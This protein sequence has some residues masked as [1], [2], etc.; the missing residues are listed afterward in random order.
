MGQDTGQ[1]R[2]SEQDTD[3]AI[4]G[5]SAHLPGADG[6]GAYW[7]NLA[8][9]IRS[10]RKLDDAALLEAGERPDRLRDPN[11]VRAAAPLDGFDMFDGEFFGFSPRDSAILDPQHRRF[12]ETAWEALENAGHVPERFAGEI[13]V[14]AGCGMGSYLYFNLCSHPDLVRDVGMFL[15]RHTGNDK[16]FLAT[17]VSNIFDLRGPSIGVQTACS[18]SL[19]AVHYAARALLSGDCDMAL[20]GGVTIEL[21]QGRGYVYKPGEVLSPDGECHAFDARAEGTVF[22]SGAGVVVLRRLSDALADGDHI[23]A[24]LKGSA[25]NNDG[26]QKAGYLAPSVGRQADAVA[27]A[28]DAA[29]VPA[30]SI[31]YVECHGTGTY[32]GDPIEISALTDAFRR[33]TD[34]RGFCRIGSVKTNIGHL[35]TA[36]GAASLIKA[37]LALHHR[38][39]PPSLG[40]ETPNPAIDFDSSPFVVNDT[41]A[42]WPADWPSKGA[43]R[44]AGV[45]SL[46]VGGTNAHAVLEEAPARGAS[47]PSDWPFHILNVSGRSRAALDA[48]AARLAAHLRAHPEQPLADVAF[49]LKEG[50]RAFARR[51]VLV[52]ETHEEAAA[53]LEANDPYRVFTHEALGEDPGVVFMFP[54]GGAQY[55]GMARDLYETEP[56]FRDWMDR[57]LGLLQPELDF[58]LRAVWL[59]EPAARDAAEARLKTP[60]VQL[61]L[62]MITEYAL[63]QLWM[64]WGVRPAALVGHSMGENTAACLAGVIPFADCI[65]LV[66]LRGRLFDTVPKGGMLSVAMPADALRPLL[67]ADLDIACLNAPEMTVLSGPAAAL[68]A[69]EARLDAE[70]AESRRIGIDIAAHSRMLDPILAEF[71]D[72]LRGLALSAPRIPFVS[73]RTGTWITDEQATDPGYWAGHL[74][75]AVRF[76]DCI[77]TLA[78]D[79]ARVYLEVG[80]GAALCSLAKQNGVPANQ[81]IQSLRHPDLD[82][83]DDAYFLTVVGRLGAV[84][85]EVDWSPIWADQHRHRVPLPTYAFQRNRYFIAPAERV[86]EAAPDMPARRDDPADWGYLPVWRPAYADCP[87][88]IEAALAAAPQCWLI[89]TDTAGLGARLAARL[90][91]AGHDVAEVA[92]GDTFARTGPDSYTLAPESGRGGYDALLADLGAAGRM[93]TR[94]AHLWLVTDTEDHRPGSSFFHRNVEQGLYGL[95]H[96]A[97]ALDGA[98]SGPVHVTLATTGAAQVRT[99]P[100]AH[101]EKAMAAAAASVIPRELPGVTLASVDLE[102]AERPGAGRR[103]HRARQEEDRLDRAAAAL[104]EEM[105]AAPSNTVAAWRGERRFE[106]RFDARPLPQPAEGSGFARGGTYLITGGFGGIGLALARHLAAEYGARVA[107]VS[108]D[109]AGPRRSRALDAL[110]AAGAEVMAVAA[111]VC[112]LDDMRRAVDE[113]RA[114]FGAITGVIHA[115]GTIDDAPLLARTA[116][117]AEAVLAPKVHGTRVLDRLFPDGTLDLMVLCSSSST[118]TRPAGQYDYV[119]ANEYLN[120]FAKARRGGATRVVAVDWGIWAE[121]GMA[122]RALSGKGAEVPLDMPL[123]DSREDAASGVRLSARLSP[124][125]WILDEHRTEDGAAVLPGTG[126]LELAAEAMR[127]MGEGGPFE[128][129]DLYFL[130]PLGVAEGAQADLRLSLSPSEGG[131]ALDLRSIHDGRGTLLH[132]E[133]RLAPHAGPAPAQLDLDAIAARCA[134]PEAAVQGALRSPQEAHLRFGARWGVLRS[135]ALGQGEGL[136]RLALPDA[137]HA[138]TRTYVLHPAL[139]DIATGWAIDLAQGYSPD[140]LWVPLRYGRVIVHRPLPPEIA[141]WVRIA[142]QADGEVSFDITLA[143]PDGAVCVEIT[144]FAMSRMEGGLDLSLPARLDPDPDAPAAASPAQERLR[145]QLA[146]GIRPAEGAAALERAIATGAPQIVVSP[147]DLAALIRQA[148]IPPDMPEAG[149]ARPELDSAYAAP[150]TTTERKLAS[151]WQQLLGV[152][153]IGTDDSFFDLGGHSLIAVRLFAAIKREFGVEFPISTLFEAPTIAA[154]AALIDA[155]TGGEAGA[156]ADASEAAA[157]AQTFTHLVPLGGQGAR[158]GRAPFFLVAG[159]FGNVMNLRHL[160]QLIGPRRAVYG[161]QARGLLGGMDPHDTLEAAAADCIAEL[162]QVQPEGPYLL[163]GFSGGGLTAYE[164]ARQLEAAGE[165]VALLVM[166]DTPLPVR[167]AL[168]RRDKALIKAQELRAGGAGFVRHWLAGKLRWHLNRRRGAPADAAEGFQNAAIEAAFRRAVTRYDLRAWT[169]PALLLR[170]P[171]D[172]R[173]R[174]SG[175]RW[176]STAREYVFEDNDWSRFIGD[177]RVAEVPGDHDSM[178]L[179]PNVRVLA[180]ELARALDAAEAGESVDAPGAAPLHATAAE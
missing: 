105:L 154:C 150:A 78:E 126:Y 28:H 17:R 108:R 178:V 90:R 127:A 170:P 109:A 66:H 119:A 164:M 69:V 169:G 146:D 10:I 91:K 139:M 21:P 89:F 173:W 135:R 134:P 48:N 177:L 103:R 45:N 47:A 121:V 144:G 142:S 79:P 20:A 27:A 98:G 12:L 102:L 133:G 161:L 6:I 40:Y 49:T 46:G 72:F 59:P 13:G 68:D 156:D 162:R 160:A 123:L 107:L 115:A 41:L 44:R 137:F 82:I 73:N 96:L 141:S 85:V 155:R 32:L 56:V 54:G 158:D 97:Q 58:D 180:A 75:H 171:L 122:A 74:R 101:P 88:D 77:A 159:M 83:A 38:Q 16:D 167:P 132:A 7:S 128:I 76:A 11:Y 61:P 176:V 145:A 26:A 42:D 125:S 149:F 111:D 106:Q 163:G 147:L 19:V 130:R 129:R 138:E 179:E 52:A 34:A 8:R 116:A 55:A 1:D 3:I 35:D 51:R 29:G 33:G 4:T 112:N 70:G 87:A 131:H 120:A 30:G 15:L 18:T 39:I 100:L 65:R 94:I 153:E 117:E 104:L 23:W 93:P 67:P 53:L 175:G 43:P 174:V 168:S 5:M 148:D 63:A 37:A 99:E 71:T 86:A 114:R 24:V 22:G 84:G 95:M 172:R 81:V 118:A 157:P 140:W 92:A 50:R 36:A 152:E 60:S 80:P 143:G 57:G 136:A 9:G 62:L 165:R 110:R 64:S 2:R 124:E 31:G 14:F 166:L 151:L 25:V 113:V